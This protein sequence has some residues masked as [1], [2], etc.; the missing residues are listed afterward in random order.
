M[1]QATE[2]P[3]R[4]WHGNTE[5]LKMFLGIPGNDQESSFTN[6][7]LQSTA[8]DPNL[9]FSIAVHV[10]I[11]ALVRSEESLAGWLNL[12]FE[13]FVYQHPEVHVEIQIGPEGSGEEDN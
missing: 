2:S 6:A 3:E 4:P 10:E 11:P 7:T 12:I 9:E 13:D 8:N 5:R 1:E